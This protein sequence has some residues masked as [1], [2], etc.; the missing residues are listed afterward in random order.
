MPAD[1]AGVDA[2]AATRNGLEPHH[3]AV[4]L[5]E[6]EALFGIEALGGHRRRA[7]DV[8]GAQLGRAAGRE[9]VD[10][11]LRLEP[12]VEVLVAGEDDV[13]VV[14]DEQRLDDRPQVDFRSVPAAR[15]IDRVMEVG[16][17]P[18]RVRLRQLVLEPALL[19]L[20]HV[21]AVEGEEAHVLLL[22]GVEALAAH[23]EVL[24]EALVRIVVIAERGVERDVGVEQRLVGPLELRDE[25]LRPLGAVHVVAEHD[26]ELVREDRV[27]LPHLRAGF[28]LRAIAGAAV[29][30]HQELDRVLADRRLH[31]DWRAD[32]AARRPARAAV[33]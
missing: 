10:A 19:V 11:L 18:L 8:A 31:L 5:D 6:H 7:D 16:D 2:L 17:L 24:V 13:E 26:R 4:D 9:V 27:R 25:V 22:I 29:A 33:R 20:V 3:V 28:G 32:I 15:R 21:V 14:L 12:L 30:D 1:L 23:A